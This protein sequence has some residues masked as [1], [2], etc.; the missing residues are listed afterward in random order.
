MPLVVTQD[1]WLVEAVLAAG[2]SVGVGPLVTGDPAVVSRGWRSASC[3]IV[4]ADRAALVASLGLAARPGVHLVGVDRDELLSWS[5]P[6]DASVVVLPD[7]RMLLATV[8]DPRLDDGVGPALLVR[9]VGASGGV[10]ASTLAAGLAHAGARRSLGAVVVELDPCGG[11]LDLLLG[12][13]SVPGWRWNDLRGASGRIESLA[14]H[15][16]GVSGVDVL[17]MSRPVFSLP[18]PRLRRAEGAVPGLGPVAPSPD[19]VRT[20]VAALT[21]SHRLV[22]LDAGH[23][24]GGVGDQWTGTR[25]LAVVAAHPRG[26]VAASARLAQLAVPDVSLVVRAGP[27]RDLDPDTVGRALGCP[28]AGVVHDDRRLPA[29]EAVGDPPGRA[30]GRFRREV[31]RFLTAV[32]DGD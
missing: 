23:L 8:L 12:A 19:A 30:H 4:G 14:G 3:V 10:G 32:I 22:V 31:E 20:V 28:V 18:R 29:S 15:L 17:A 7:Q 1:E 26:I 13:E 11:G 16:P 6:L 27:G 21:R 24:P 2:V 25:T 9:V 5:V